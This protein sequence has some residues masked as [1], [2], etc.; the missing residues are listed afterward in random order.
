MLKYSWQGGAEEKNWL[1]SIL[2]SFLVSH[3]IPQMFQHIG[4]GGEGAGMVDLNINLYF[5]LG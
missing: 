3:E 2:N 1:D 4:G 5:T